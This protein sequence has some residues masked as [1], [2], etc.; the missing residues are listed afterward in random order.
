VTPYEKIGLTY[1]AWLML[2]GLATWFLARWSARRQI[3]TIVFA[4]LILIA[5]V[6]LAQIGYVL[7]FGESILVRNR[8][9]L[10]RFLQHTDIVWNSLLALWPFASAIGIA[11]TS[12]KIADR[13]ALARWTSFGCSVG[14]AALTPLMVVVVWCKLSGA[15]L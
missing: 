1:G 8:N 10:E 14:I 6:N 5:V 3:H 15:C 11:Q 9:P 7:V 2:C 13:P 4:L 12:L